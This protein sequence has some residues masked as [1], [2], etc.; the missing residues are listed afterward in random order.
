MTVPTPFPLPTGNH[1]FESIYNALRAQARRY[2]RSEQNAYSMSPTILVHEA[3]IS[4]A[5]SRKLNIGDASHYVRLVSR[6]MKN[7]L[8]DHARRKKAAARG[9]C[10]QRTEWNDTTVAPEA[11]CDLTLAIATA[12]DDLAVLSPRLATL[13]ELR[14]FGGFTET[15]VAQIMGISSR[16]VRRQWRVARLRLLEALQSP[17]SHAD[18]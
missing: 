1:T 16:S 6:V 11:D 3:W 8:I 10:L 17:G 13:V 7:L 15:E 5:R 9:G 12:L 18:A 2:L 14:Y 4:L